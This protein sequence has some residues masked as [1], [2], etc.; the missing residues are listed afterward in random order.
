MKKQV[1][2]SDI[3][4]QLDSKYY[5]DIGFKD[6]GIPKPPDDKIK[7]AVM[8]RLNGPEETNL[9]EYS[10]KPPICKKK[11][12][13]SKKPFRILLIAAALCLMSVGVFAATGG[14]SYFQSIFGDSADNVKNDILSPSISASNEDYKLAV[15]SML[16]DGYKTDLVVSLESL[17]GNKINKD[18]QNLFSVNYN[19]D[20]G[21][22]ECT[23][24][25]NF[26]KGNIYYYDIKIT[27]LKN[28]LSSTLKVTMNGQE[29]PLKVDVPVEHSTACKTVTVNTA[30]YKNK[31]YKPESLELS[32]LGVMLI[33]SEEK[34]SEKTSV[35]IPTMAILMKDGSKQDLELDDLIGFDAGNVKESGGGVVCDDDGFFNIFNKS[36]PLVTESS[37][38][39]NPGGKDVV[40]G[41]FSRIL[42]LD[43]VK[44][45]LVDGQEYTI[46]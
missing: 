10:S 4:S 41:Y 1:R 31:R 26:D 12:T 44:A 2:I 14:L 39:R 19:V 9:M 23:S 25:S 33:G 11:K 30:A 15:E 34:S 18:P 29:K 45:I 36:K 17:K 3:C 35:K 7:N 43:N 21:S 27:S 16:S 6:S 22:Y 38:D 46:K 42:D 32:P 37:W 20:C 13:I 24:L 8:S 28:Y 40:A 5:S